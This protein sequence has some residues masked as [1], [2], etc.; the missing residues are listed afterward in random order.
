MGLK[1]WL[2]ATEEEHTTFCIIFI[3]RTTHRMPP[4]STENASLTQTKPINF[5]FLFRNMLKS[6]LQLATL[7]SRS[8]ALCQLHV[9]GMDN[10]CFV[11]G[12]D[13]SNAMLHS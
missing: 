7:W 11:V 3:D 4:N 10:E 8:E 9:W 12:V 5:S 1:D 13:A 2:I 6:E